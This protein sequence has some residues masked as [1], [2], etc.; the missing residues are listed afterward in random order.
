VTPRVLSPSLPLRPLSC[1]RPESIQ[2][3]SIDLSHLDIAGAQVIGQ[4]DNKFIACRIFAR[5]HTSTAPPDRIAVTRYFIVVIDQHAADERIRLESI[6]ND[7]TVQVCSGGATSKAL[8]GDGATLRLTPAEQKFFNQV[9]LA[10]P[11][12]HRWGL[13]CVLQ[14]ELDFSM[15][16]H[17]LITTVPKLFANRMAFENSE[18][19]RAF[20]D[21]VGNLIDRAASD[22]TIGAL[23]ERFE[24]QIVQS[25]NVLSWC[26]PRFIELAKSNACRGQPLR[27][28]T[29]GM[30]RSHRLHIGLTY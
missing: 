20:H 2:P 13:T 27:V 7:L 22:A 10:V 21:Y 25:P 18:V 5:K 15:R 28:E 4:V 9:P 6:L 30:S 14:A 11:L 17:A 1:L 8:V 29:V 19:E 24:L 26:P 16:K 23:L 3:P 12:L